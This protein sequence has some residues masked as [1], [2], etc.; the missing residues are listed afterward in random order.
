MAAQR[1]GMLSSRA[2]LDV[3]VLTFRV[4]GIVHLVP[5]FAA[6]FS[7]RECNGVEQVSELSD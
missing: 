7:A 5:L 3:R 1:V 4:L 6:C 2:V